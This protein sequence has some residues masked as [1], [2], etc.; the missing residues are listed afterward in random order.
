MNIV[1]ATVSFFQRWNDFRSR[2]SRSEY[3]WPILS[4]G[5]PLRLLEYF[6]SVYVYSPANMDAGFLINLSG[7]SFQH[8]LIKSKIVKP[9]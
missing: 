6:M 7:S 5:I 8:L 4:I 3:W 1:D 2:S 9:L